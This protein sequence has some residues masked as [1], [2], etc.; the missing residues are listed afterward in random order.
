[1]RNRLLGDA[2]AELL[3]TATDDALAACP[4]AHALVE[5]GSFC[6]KGTTVL[7]NVVRTLRPTAK[8]WAMDPHDGL[9]GAVDQGLH[10][11]PPTLGTFRQ[12]IERCGLAPYVE[13][14][15]SKA[16]SV[17][18]SRAI[19]LLLIDGLHDFASVSA[20]FLHFE[21][22]LADSAIVIFHDYA[23]YYPGVRRFVDELLVTGRYQM[24]N[25]AESLVVLRKIPV[26]ATEE[27]AV[28]PRRLAQ[29]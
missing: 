28:P 25:R 19:C 3:M 26:R 11:E 2:E 22:F 24:V 16:P 15:Q 18:W 9:V 12:T 7:A 23:D 5:V 13:T 8:V 29:V 14:V 27:D 17:S 21:P 6:G 4:D 1:M 10:Q 20:D